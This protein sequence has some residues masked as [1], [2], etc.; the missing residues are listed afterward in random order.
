MRKTIKQ[1]SVALIAILVSMVLGTGSPNFAQ[2]VADAARQERE[3]RHQ[4]ALHATHVYTNEDLAKP[5]ILVPEDEAR[6][7]ARQK[8][9]TPSESALDAQASPPQA[10]PEVAAEPI[11]IP[12]I[13]DAVSAP[14]LPEV[15]IAS[16][17]ACISSD[18][19]AK[20]ASTPRCQ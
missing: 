9:T 13:K 17:A 15:A 6:V 3:R 8:D 5:R 7:A 10:A 20:V 1:H 16:S 4:L 19:P 18:L 12:D 14:E 2:S 11:E